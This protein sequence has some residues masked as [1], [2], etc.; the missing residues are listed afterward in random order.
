[1]DSYH[2]NCHKIPRLLENL[3]KCLQG[4]LIYWNQKFHSVFCGFSYLLF[5]DQKVFLKLISYLFKKLYDSH[6]ESFIPKNAQMILHTSSIS[7]SRT[8][9]SH[10]F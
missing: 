10:A 5:Y 6:E 8:T 7:E 4:C 1:M 2:V 9:N 3:P